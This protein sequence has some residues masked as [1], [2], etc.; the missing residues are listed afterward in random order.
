MILVV[1]TGCEL[2][3]SDHN[4]GDGHD[5]GDNDYNRCVALGDSITEGHG[6]NSGE[7]YPAQLAVMIG[8]T[9]IN[10]GNGGE[11]SDSGAAR[12]DS[13]L[14]RHKPG[15]IFVLYGANDIIHGRSH[16][17]TI[18]SLRTIINKAKENKTI[19]VIATLT[20]ANESHSF[21]SGDI[22]QLNTLIRQL[23]AETGTTLVDLA[24]AFG[25][26]TDL[27]DDDGLHPN[28]NGATVIALSF[29]GIF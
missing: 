6:L 10:E 28:A 7:E 27:L 12:T 9:V 4:L 29:A 14:R 5:F 22:E 3:G 24:H 15:Y 13:V 16:A 17:S 2:D 18:E 1:N 11:N 20:P 8:K 21:M 25:D 26:G 23:T 19:P